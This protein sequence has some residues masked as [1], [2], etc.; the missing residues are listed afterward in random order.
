MPA[1]RHTGVGDTSVSSLRPSLVRAKKKEKK[2]AAELDDE[3][4]VSG[5]CF[6]CTST[7]REGTQEAKIIKVHAA[8]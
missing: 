3:G 7:K 5:A 4:D 2:N 6:W 8:E 1:G